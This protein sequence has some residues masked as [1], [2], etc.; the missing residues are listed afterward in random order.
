MRA[1]ENLGRFRVPKMHAELR[2][3]GIDIG[4]DQTGRL[5]RR[6]GLQG[7]RRGKPKRTTTP[8]QSAAR[9]ADLVERDFTAARPNQL[10]VT[11]IT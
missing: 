1:A 8:D 4:R 7:V 5:M 3:A 10:W 11:D 2:R 6:L 9:P